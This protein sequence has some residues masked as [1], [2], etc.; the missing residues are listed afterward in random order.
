M[1]FNYTCCHHLANLG[2]ICYL[3]QVER[4]SFKNSKMETR[5]SKRL[6][7]T[8]DNL[9]NSLFLP[10]LSVCQIIFLFLWLI[11]CW[12]RRIMEL[13]DQTD[14][15]TKNICNLCFRVRLLASSGERVCA[16]D[17]CSCMPTRAELCCREVICASHLRQEAGK[18]KMLGDTCCCGTCR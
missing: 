16:D 15:L 10:Q 13:R 12:C 1:S 18:G 9:Q 6:V 11:Y 17:R 5:K 8:S 3:V 2:Y 7:E 14:N 4:F